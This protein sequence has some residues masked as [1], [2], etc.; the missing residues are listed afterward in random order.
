MACGIIRAFRDNSSQ[1]F[2]YN[3]YPYPFR[4][5]VSGEFFRACFISFGIALGSGVVVG[6]FVWLV[7]GMENVEYFEDRAFWIINDDGIR[8]AKGEVKE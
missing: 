4:W 2:N 5:D 3:L 8:G 1:V 6:F 7:S